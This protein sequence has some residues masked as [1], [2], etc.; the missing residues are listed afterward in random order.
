MRLSIRWLPA[1]LA[2]LCSASAAA[3]T[4]GYASGFDVTTAQDSLY[5][6]NLETGAATLH[7]DGG[8][9]QA[10]D[11]VRGTVVAADEARVDG[12]VGAREADARDAV[13]GR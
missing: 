10:G 13:A 5:R 2:L 3:Q 12:V 1:L 11:D 4:L 9:G 8:R 6:I 7:Q